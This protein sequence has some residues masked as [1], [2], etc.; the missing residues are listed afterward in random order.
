MDTLKSRSLVEIKLKS[1]I[2][3]NVKRKRAA[4]GP[5]DH[6]KHMTQ[7]TLLT[8]NRVSSMSVMESL[9][10]DVVGKICEEVD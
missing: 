8:K 1:L 7:D 2:S 5:K 3:L 9:V 4:T 10:S 6:L